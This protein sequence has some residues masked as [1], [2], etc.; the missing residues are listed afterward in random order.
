MNLISLFGVFCI[1][2]ITVMP[3]L[4]NIFCVCSIYLFQFHSIVLFLYTKF[5]NSLHFQNVCLFLWCLIHSSSQFQWNQ[6]EKYIMEFLLSSQSAL[7]F[8]FADIYQS[9]LIFL[10]GF[11]ND[12]S[13]Q[14]LFQFISCC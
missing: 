12:I 1:Q 8:G 5:M 3:Y 9:N 14:F 13:N 10:V 4:N 6:F 11:F 2:V 7:T